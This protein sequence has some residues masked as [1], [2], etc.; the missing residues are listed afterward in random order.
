MTKKKSDGINI[1]INVGTDKKKTRRK[2][3]PS[4]R[5]PKTK[6]PQ[7]SGDKK[8]LPVAPFGNMAPMTGAL[9][10]TYMQ[11]PKP[12][13]LN[14]PPNFNLSDIERLIKTK[15][16]EQKEIVRTELASILSDYLPGGKYNP[17]RIAYEESSDKPTVEDITH[18]SEE[19]EEE[20]AEKSSSSASGMLRRPS[21]S[22]LTP[23][24]SS[25]LL[26]PATFSSPDYSP[27]MA[28]SV[29]SLIRAQTPPAVLRPFRPP[30]PIIIGASSSTPRASPAVAVSPSY[31][32]Y[33]WKKGAVIDGFEYD[34]KKKR[35]NKIGGLTY[36]TQRSAEIKYPLTEENIKKGLWVRK[37]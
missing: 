10:S 6:E 25:T 27:A 12:T 21:S 14:A 33:V 8:N 9:Y 23:V 13:V 28:S 15:P 24:E 32:D 17:R 37:K 35:Y 30:S 36:M 7:L 29:E 19:E 5:K 34:P 1:S 4:T 26:T 2:R 31:A 18:L 16:D 11:P 20:K 22:T 3:K